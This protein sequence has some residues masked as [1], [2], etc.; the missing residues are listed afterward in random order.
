MKEA[1][2]QIENVEKICLEKIKSEKNLSKQNI[3][4][5]LNKSKDS[6]ENAKKQNIL[7]SKKELKIF[8]EGLEIKELEFKKSLK[9]KLN[10]Y[11]EEIKKNHKM[12]IES[13]INYIL[14]I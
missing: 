5:E 11:E 12:A 4:T 2:L 1:I 14:N 7:H 8:K 6:I 3:K 9:E 13:V 10:A